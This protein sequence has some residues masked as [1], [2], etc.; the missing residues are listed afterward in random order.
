M[1]SL[2]PNVAQ[3]QDHLTGELPLKR[4]V[5]VHQIRHL[6]VRIDSIQRERLEESEVYVTPGRRRSERILVG[7]RSAPDAGCCGRAQPG[8]RRWAW[9]RAAIIDREVNGSRIYRGERGCKARVAT[10]I[11][12]A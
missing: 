11:P 4:K 1:P 6:V 3:G 5:I 2:R 7:N 12:D 10:H 9:V 8:L